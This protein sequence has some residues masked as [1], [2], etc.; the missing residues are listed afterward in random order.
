MKLKISTKPMDIIASHLA[1]ILVLSHNFD[2]RTDDGSHELTVNLA[3]TSEFLLHSL[4]KVDLCTLTY[5]NEN[6][7]RNGQYIGKSQG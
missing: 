3:K 5:D 7:S 6:A 2:V 4:I 1:H